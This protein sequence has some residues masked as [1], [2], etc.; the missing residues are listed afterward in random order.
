MPYIYI[1]TPIP[2]HLSLSLYLI[3]IPLYLYPYEYTLM[4]ISWY[5]YSYPYTYTLVPISLWLYTY[6][7]TLVLVNCGV[8][9][10]YSETRLG[11]W[12]T[13]KMFSYDA[14]SH[15]AAHIQE[16]FNQK[17][18]EFKLQLDATKYVVIFFVHYLTREK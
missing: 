2:L 13:P 14:P 5:L 15:S 11:L 17:W 4:T 6:T 8:D 1:L 18:R 16:F 3:S 12:K 7:Y 10:F 9:F